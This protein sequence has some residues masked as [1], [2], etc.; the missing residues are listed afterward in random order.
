[1][2]GAAFVSRLLELRRYPVQIFAAAFPL[3]NV[4]IGLIWD[5]LIIFGLGGCFPAWQRTVSIVESRDVPQ[6]RA[7]ASE[8]RKAPKVVGSHLK[9]PHFV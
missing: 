3:G 2:C 1:M 6:A 7:L 8:G 4:D 9:I 5:S